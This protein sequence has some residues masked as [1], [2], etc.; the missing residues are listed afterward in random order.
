MPKGF[1]GFR[2]G[3]V[4]GNSPTV[5]ITIIKFLGNALGDVAIALDNGGLRC[6]GFLAGLDGRNGDSEGVEATKDGSI[7]ALIRGGEVELLAHI[8]VTTTTTT[9]TTTATSRGGDRVGR[10]IGLVIIGI[11]P[12][13]HIEDLGALYG[14]SLG[15]RVGE[16]VVVVLVVH[17]HD[18][19]VVVVV[20]ILLFVVQLH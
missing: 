2:L 14:G 17:N 20:V 3:G 16:V 9:T 10:C 13:R 8:L 7:L 4:L 19:I 5:H 15:S 18:H 11:F 6:L 12:K 1:T